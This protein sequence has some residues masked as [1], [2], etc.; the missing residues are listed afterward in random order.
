MKLRRI[1]SLAVTTAALVTTVAAP[2]AATPAPAPATGK[3]VAFVADLLPATVWENPKG[4]KQL[5]LGTHVIFNETE[6]PIEVFAD[7]RCFVPLEPFAR[8]EPGRS[9]HVSAAGSFRA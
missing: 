1:A 6:A 9:M 8:L 5:P 3:V 2:A 7:P 4:C